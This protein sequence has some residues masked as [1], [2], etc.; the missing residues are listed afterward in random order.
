MHH[1]A[2]TI[3]HTLCTKHST[4]TVL[5]LYSYRT[6]TIPVPYSYCTHTLLIHCTH[7]AP[8]LY[9][10][11][12]HT[13]PIPYPYRTL[14]VFDRSSAI[15]HK[16]I[17]KWELDEVYEHWRIWRY[18]TARTLHC[19]HTLY[20]YT[21]LIQHTH[22]TILIPVLIHYTHTARTLHCTHTL[23]S[24]TI[25]IQHA[26]YTVLIHC[27]HTLYSYST[28]TTPYTIHHT[29]CLDRQALFPPE[30]IRSGKKRR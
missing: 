1:R 8:I 24:Y 29:L 2:Y 30:L 4:H 27:T 6:H 22:Y 20:S 5:V 21:I 14:G 12:T 19:T 15:S 9:P 16:L 3:E 17:G 26:H 10:Y 7:T 13:V 28:H 23:Y 11:C 18:G 25:L